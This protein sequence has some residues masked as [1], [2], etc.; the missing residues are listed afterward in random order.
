M[1]HFIEKAQESLKS[2]FEIF[3]MIVAFLIPTI[4]NATGWIELCFKNTKIDFDNIKYYFLMKTGN[5]T[6]GVLLTLFVLNTI[7]K[8]N[9][10]RIF[11]TKNVYHDYSYIWYWFCAKILGYKKCNLKLVPIYM[12]F[13][14]GFFQFG[15]A[16]YGVGL[17]VA[18][19]ECGIE[20]QSGRGSVKDTALN[21]V[22][23]IM[24]VGLFS[25]V[26]VRLYQLCVSLQASFTAGITGFGTDVGTLA[27]LARS[28]LKEKA[29]E[30]MCL[31]TEEMMQG[32]CKN[33]VIG[34][35]LQ[36]LS[37][38]LKN[39]RGKKVYGYLKADV[40]RLVDQIVDELAKESTVAEAYRAWSA[41]YTPMMK[42]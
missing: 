2:I 30:R 31:L 39:T 8:N 1:K 10:E 12:Q 25:V 15:W 17:V 41:I 3:L 18:V 26:P 5:L 37:E 14:L 22:K 34:E 24:A 29:A 32:V 19:F 6:I 7:R 38:R 27:N 40:K 28:S 9:K 35:K 4:I 16:L 33:P 23:G 20:Y 11:N 36:L 21:A 42:M 13:K